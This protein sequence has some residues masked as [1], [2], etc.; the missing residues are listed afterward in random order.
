MKKSFFLL[1]E[2]VERKDDIK[3]LMAEIR[4]SDSI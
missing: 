1:E 4:V 2:K 3:L